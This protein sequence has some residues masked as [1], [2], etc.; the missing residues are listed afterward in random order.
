MRGEER[1]R[2]S[3]SEKLYSQATARTLSTKTS[4]RGRQLEKK[5]KARRSRLGLFLFRK[6]FSWTE[7]FFLLS[8]CGF[9]CLG[10]FTI[11]WCWL[12]FIA[13]PSDDTKQRHKERDDKEHWRI[14]ML[15]T[16]LMMHLISLLEI[17]AVPL[18]WKL[19]QCHKSAFRN[20]ITTAKKAIIDD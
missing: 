10:L 5:N 13:K 16:H 2:K 8:C 3:E 14:F 17:N 18:K 20:K 11:S 12:N 6:I 19:V 7:I 1:R 15:C 4:S 9:W